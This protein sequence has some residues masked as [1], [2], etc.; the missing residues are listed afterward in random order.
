M[1]TL[2]HAAKLAATKA[3]A[4]NNDEFGII[5]QHLR[6]LRKLTSV[7][8]GRHL[9]AGV[10]Y[11]LNLLETETE[12]ETRRIFYFF[13]TWECLE[14]ELNI[15]FLRLFVQEFP[16]DFMAYQSLATAL[17]FLARY[18]GGSKTDASVAARHAFELAKKHQEMVKY[19]GV[20]MARIGLWVDDYPLLEFALTELINDAPNKREIDYRYEFDFIKQIDKSQLRDPTLVDRYLALGSARQIE[21]DQ[22]TK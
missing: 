15:E 10:A 4:M 14:L 19:C 12:P 21:H 7:Y 8:K 2:P 16:E 6:T 20:S 11:M 3:A 22:R 1:P 17:A 9:P 18:E 5:Q 13:L